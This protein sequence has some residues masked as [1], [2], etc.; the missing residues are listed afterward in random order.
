MRSNDM[1]KRYCNTLLAVL[2]LILLSGC[3]N[4]L[5]VKEVSPGD[6]GQIQPDEAVIFGRVR[7]IENGKEKEDYS[8]ITESLV[9]RLVR[10]E[11]ER[12]MANKPIKNN[13]TF[14]WRIPRGT[15]L[16]RRL[17]WHEFRGSYHL[18]PQVAFQIGADA[19]AYYL[20]TVEL[21]AEV[22]RPLIMKMKVKGLR[23]TVQ[24]EYEKDSG[25]LARHIHHN[26]GG[27]KKALMVHNHSLPC[28]D[29]DFERN[30]S[31]IIRALWLLGFTL[32]NVL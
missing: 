21:K 8:S 20:G 14:L 5:K 7:L 12:D 11:D 18:Y 23:V 27:F 2:F 13:G 30:R 29:S 22:S 28:R 26:K 3:L 25:I 17:R 6:R 10:M 19:N 16:M 24:D 9:M 4:T 15:Y 31:S 32:Q 1:I